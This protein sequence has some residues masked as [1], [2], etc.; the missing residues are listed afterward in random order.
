MCV[1]V[2]LIQKP[3]SSF[4]R[5]RKYCLD[6]NNSI[7]EFPFYFIGCQW[8]FY[9][10]TSEDQFPLKF[11]LLYCLEVVA[12]EWFTCMWGPASV[13]NLMTVLYTLV[14]IGAGRGTHCTG[15]WPKPS[16]ERVNFTFASQWLLEYWEDF[17]L[18]TRSL[19]CQSQLK[20]F[21]NT[22]QNNPGSDTYLRDLNWKSLQLKLVVIPVRWVTW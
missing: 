9:S 10:W 6:Q 17:N 18:R 3:L 5:K 15:E 14:F 12:I 8:H 16:G 21:Q 2:R 1:K 4:Q 11:S 19:K 7:E 13:S 22:L 20:A